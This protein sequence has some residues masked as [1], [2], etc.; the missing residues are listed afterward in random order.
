MFVYFVQFNQIMPISYLFSSVDTI[1]CTI[2]FNLLHL[3]Q[4][5]IADLDS[6]KERY[7]RQIFIVILDHVMHAYRV[8]GKPSNQTPVTRV[9]ARRIV[10][11]AEK[12]RMPNTQPV[13]SVHCSK[14]NKVYIFNLNVGLWRQDEICMT[15]N[16]IFLKMC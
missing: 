5:Q 6:T 14:T 1:N 9:P 15:I 3:L 11:E 4:L 16:V 10:A 12:W 7:P 13:V 2:Y 8:P